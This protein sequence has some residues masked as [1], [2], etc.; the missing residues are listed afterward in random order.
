M[1]FPFPKSW[2]LATVFI[3]C[4]L[5]VAVAAA[6]VTVCEDKT[7]EQFQIGKSATFVKNC[8]QIRRKFP[9]LCNYNSNVQE[10]CQFSC[11]L[12]GYLANESYCVDV[13][14]TF[15]IAA[16]TI[17]QKQKS[18][19]N[20]E[21]NP[22]RFCNKWTFKK[23]CP[24]ACGFCEPT[25]VRCNGLDSNCDMRVNDLLYAT[26][27]NAN[28]DSFPFQNHNAP[29]EEALVA[30]YRGLMLDVCKCNGELKFCHGLCNL[31]D[32]DIVEVIANIVSF[33]HS[34]P[35]DVIII[36]FEMSLGD[37]TPA[38]LWTVMSSVPGL[39]SKV[40]EY[41]DDN[42]E[43]PTL[44]AMTDSGKQIIAF[45]HNGPNCPLGEQ[46]IAGQG[47]NGCSPKIYDFFDYTMGTHWDYDSVSDIED[48]PNSCLIKRGANGERDFYSVNNFVTNPFASP[49][50]SAIVNQ[51]DFVKK[52][53]HNC[54]EFMESEPNFINIDFWQLG[55]V[56]GFV[57]EE[58]AARAK[59]PKV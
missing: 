26:L 15:T 10:N 43:W 47:I 50:S 12:C 14:G 31:G 16:G 21:K 23:K 29:L 56:A 2:L 17:W 11:G 6:Q 24:M 19:A 35:K 48:Y 38:E 41:M 55:D 57:N 5:A 9:Q 13:Q 3:T 59:I 25:G 8:A 51:I 39:D 27:H 53:V 45:Q 49:S 28:V 34:N 18:C 32:R 36:D 33:L 1:T 4:T 40:Y 58:N 52:R 30:G 37:P 46:G 22:D 42:G 20:A 7:S 54:A 44:G